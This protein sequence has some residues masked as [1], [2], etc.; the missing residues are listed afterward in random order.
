MKTTEQSTNYELR[1]TNYEFTKKNKTVNRISFVLCIFSFS[2]FPFL[3]SAQIPG[4]KQMK[5]FG[6]SGAERIYSLYQTL[7]SGYIYAGITNSW[8]GDGDLEDT[9]RRKENRTQVDGL[10]DTW[11]VKLDK[12]L[13]IQWQRVLGGTQLD[14]ASAI[15]Q[16]RDSNFVVAGY[17]YSNDG[18]MP[19]PHPCAPILTVCKD[20]W[21]M[22]LNNRGE[23]LWK[24]SLGGGGDEYI[25][26]IQQLSDGG[27]VL[28]GLTNSNDGD[29]DKK[30]Y[31]DPV[32]FQDGGGDAW[33]VKIKATGEIVWQKTIGGS[34]KDEFL[35]LQSVKDGGFIAAGYTNS[36]DGDL[37]NIKSVFSREAWLVKFDSAFNI[38]W[39][40][41]ASRLT[42]NI[43]T[44]AYSIVET[45]KG[46]YII[47]GNTATGLAVPL[48]SDYFV[49]KF[50]SKGK[51]KWR[52]S[53]GGSSD[54][55]ARTV[56]SLDSD[57]G[58]IIGGYTFSN[59]GDVTDYK[60]GR[61]GW[62]L[63]CDSLGNKTAARCVGGSD[64]DYIFTSLKSK[65]GTYVFGGYTKSK[66]GD[67]VATHNEL[68]AW[69]IELNSE[70]L[71][72]DFPKP[73]VKNI[74]DT[75]VSSSA[76]TYKWYVNDTIIASAGKQFY[77]PQKTGYYKVL[78][79]DSSACS[80]TSD[81]IYFAVNPIYSC[82]NLN[83]NIGDTCTDNNA[84]TH[85][86]KVQADC[87]CKATIT[88]IQD[89][90]S[91][92]KILVRNVYPNP[93]E[94]NV[95]LDIFS[96]NFRKIALKLYNNMGVLLQEQ[97][98]FLNEGENKINYENLSTVSTGVYYFILNDNIN[99]AVR[100]L[101]KF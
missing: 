79:S 64:F 66:D 18:D 29:I 80:N 24:K 32:P 84:L 48:L 46:D 56:V 99:I 36:V 94:G 35:A 78:T 28:V 93:T 9:F 59:D 62:L 6:G 101:I 98:I 42:D 21:A 89:I 45:K 58:A 8:I 7:D 91:E 100:K 61:D 63:R 54:D 5:T 52:K 30:F 83:K 70:N 22:K 86:G 65:S 51:I 76:K 57:D 87:S 1:I 77:V 43:D 85:T 69:F 72:K 75:L 2:L 14:V 12:N 92:E 97:N 44:R 49:A 67:V 82:A 10:N 31:H 90:N 60:G 41:V 55:L 73:V 19:L 38:V 47:A 34:S 88:A 4:I 25:N 17:T 15:T 20:G 50:D 26:A 81:T 23:I 33:L 3:I 53:Y 68:D 37:K 13:K 96:P 16:T 95:V 27:T 71:C 11:I 74:Q 40:S 39:Q